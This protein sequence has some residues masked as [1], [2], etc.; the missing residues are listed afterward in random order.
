MRRCYLYTS[1]F[2]LTGCVGACSR[3]VIKFRLIL[4]PS[5]VNCVAFNVSTFG[6]EQVADRCF[7]RKFILCF[8]SFG[9]VQLELVFAHVREQILDVSVVGVSQGL[10]NVATADSLNSFGKHFINKYAVLGPIFDFVVRGLEGPW[11]QSLNSSF[12]SFASITLGITTSIQIF[13]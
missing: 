12:T 1:S 3:D 11:G 10:I 9:I 6:G 2:R 4:A 13:C 8:T 5:P 7:D